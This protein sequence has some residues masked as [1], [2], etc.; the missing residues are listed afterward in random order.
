M[1]LDALGGIFTK[2]VSVRPRAGAPAMRAADFPGGM[3]NA[4][5]LANPGL[6]AVRRDEIPWIAEHLRRA[7]A[8]VNVVGDTVEEYGEVVRGLTGA[9]GV[10]GFELNVSCPNVKAGGMEFGADPATLAA[11]VR[12]ARARDLAAALREAE[13]RAERHRR[14][15]AHRRGCGRR[16]HQRGEHDP[17]PA[18]GHRHAAPR[19]RL[20]HGRRERTR[21][22]CR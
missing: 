7:R 21:D 19:A 10:H 11:V 12:S 18:R 20:R 8:L 1:D 14:E 5:G 6:E 4:V 9:P 15:R 16:W 2:A 13:S 22:C 3:I 17:R